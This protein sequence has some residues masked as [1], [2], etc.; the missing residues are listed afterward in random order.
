MHAG[1]PQKQALAIAYSVKRRNMAKGGAMKVT[2][3]HMAHGG[4]LHES[5]HA[6]SKIGH[7]HSEIAK[8]AK[9]GMH[10]CAH[11]GPMHCKAGCYAEGGALEHAVGMEA[12]GEHK[13]A[14]HHETEHDASHIGH[15]QSNLDKHARGGMHQTHHVKHAAGGH[16]GS[17]HARRA[18]RAR[19]VHDTKCRQAPDGSRA[20]RVCAPRRARPR[21]PAIRAAVH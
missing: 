11:G 20:R 10:H 7:P 19:V 18:N 6:A 5:E 17:Q 8:H 1:K 13:G 15:P 16:V 3:K 12:D 9:G 14:T 21:R 2:R 4:H